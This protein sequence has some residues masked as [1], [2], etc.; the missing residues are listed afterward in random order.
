MKRLL[1]AGA[2]VLAAAPALAADLP[3]SMPPPPPPR[4]PA[5]YI[6][7]APPV[8][9]WGGIYVGLNGGYAYGS[10][11]WNFPGV[12]TGNFNI[13]GALVGGTI[14]ANF[15]T[16]QFVF[17][18][19]GDDDWTNIQGTLPA[20]NTT[21]RSCQTS[22]AWL[23]TLRARAGFAMGSRAVLRDS[24]RRRG[25]YQIVGSGGARARVCGWFYQHTEFGWTAGGG[26]EVGLTDN[27][28]AKVEYLYV[29]LQ[30]GSFACTVATCGGVVNVPVSFQTS[31]VRAGLNFKFNPF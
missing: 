21:C 16:G 13:N 31:V 7:M 28:T 25:Q 1:L 27:V 26:V 2:F 14:G 15:Q 18:I 19:E 29:D 24:R 12:R 22:N 5:A 23:A 30:N 11:N 4:A 3:P 9:N 6:P 20:A 17:G 8:Y 10:S